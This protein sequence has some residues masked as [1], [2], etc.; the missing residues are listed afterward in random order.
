LSTRFAGVV[1]LLVL[2]AGCRARATP[3]ESAAAA[4]MAAMADTTW[5]A[6]PLGAAAR[7]G[8]ALLAHTHDSLPQYAPSALR[9][10]NCHLDEG[11]RRNG[12]LLVGAFARYPQYRSRSAHMETITDRVND[13]FKRSLNG[14]PLPVDGPDMRDIVTYLAWISRGIEVFDSVP[15][16]GLP[17]LKPLPADTVRGATLFAGTCVRCHGV[18]GAG[19]AA[20]PPLW[21]PRS[22]NIGAGMARLNTA[23]AFIR[24]NMPFDKPGS[25]TDQEA[26]DIASFVISRPRPDYPG[27]ELDW[28]KGDPPPDVAYPTAA[29]AKRAAAASRPTPTSAH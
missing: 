13:C 28:P 17:K 5:P 20:V 12:L 11:M 7:R 14:Q 29:A 9:C 24:T 19:M 22:F 15:G 10:F 16:Q 6:S 1:L 8:H 2:G 23:A 3:D 25:L 26:F 4:R 21:G 27:K 18:D